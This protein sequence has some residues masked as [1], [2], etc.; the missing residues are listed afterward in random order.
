MLFSAIERLLRPGDLAGVGD[1]VG[2]FGEAL[3]LGGR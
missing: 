3:F 2:M 1:I